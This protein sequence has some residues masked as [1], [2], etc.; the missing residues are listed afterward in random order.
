MGITGVTGTKGAYVG[1]DPVF[2]MNLPHALG[3]FVLGLAMIVLPELAPALTSPNALGDTTT[4]WLELM[5]AM[6]FLIGSGYTAK[7]LAA[8]L[9]KAPVPEEARVSATVRARERS[10]LAADGNQAT[11]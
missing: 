1:L 3:F 11:V 10:S 9:P 4:L 7:G 8:A 2:I 6:I 5:G